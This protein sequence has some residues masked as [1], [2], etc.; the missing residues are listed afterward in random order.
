MSPSIYGYSLNFGDKKAGL[1][2]KNCCLKTSSENA[3]ERH[4]I[5]MFMIIIIIIAIIITIDY[6]Y[7]YYINT[8]SGKLTW[9]CKMNQLK[10][11]VALKIGMFFKL[12]YVS[13]FIKMYTHVIKNIYV[14][15][16]YYKI[17]QI[18]SKTNRKTNKT[19]PPPKRR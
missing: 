18:S 2:A 5:I 11:Y 10:M 8:C 13:S 6:H 16:V 19:K 4:T 12:L 17:N 1:K 9:Q 14:Y 15:T 3:L 7:Y